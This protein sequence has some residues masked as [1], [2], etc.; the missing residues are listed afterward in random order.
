MS[1]ACYTA[2]FRELKSILEPDVEVYKK[3]TLSMMTLDLELGL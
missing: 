2:A 1:S 3:E